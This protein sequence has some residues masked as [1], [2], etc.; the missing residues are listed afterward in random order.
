MGRCANNLR[1]GGHPSGINQPFGWPSVS[2]VLEWCCGM[3][4]DLPRIQG[5]TTTE[6]SPFAKPHETVQAKLKWN[7]ESQDTRRCT[8]GDSGPPGFT[9][10]EL[11]AYFVG[12]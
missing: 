12:E 10:T 4:L 7:N 9:D 6:I 5:E 3:V 8:A 1:P 2:V 11:L